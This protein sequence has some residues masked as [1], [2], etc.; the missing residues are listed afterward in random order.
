MI[1]EFHIAVVIREL[2][3]VVVISLVGVAVAALLLVLGSLTNY[4]RL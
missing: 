4:G 3:W 2:R 1:K